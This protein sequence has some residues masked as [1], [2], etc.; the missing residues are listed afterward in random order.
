MTVVTPLARGPL[1]YTE[2]MVLGAIAFTNATV[3]WI[4]AATGLD[5]QA[6]EI[7]LA[8]LTRRGL[9]L[10]SAERAQPRCERCAGFTHPATRN[11]PRPPKGDRNQKAR[12]DAH[13]QR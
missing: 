11:P 3:T 10:R 6:V 12:S 13:H 4:A 1:S 5:E 2:Q 9:V 7:A 8:Q